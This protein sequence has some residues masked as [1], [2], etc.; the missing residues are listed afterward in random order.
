MSWD[1]D[2]FAFF[3]DLEGQAEAAYEA[4]RSAE[5]A[6][7]S[8]AEY[9]QVVLAGRLTASLGSPLGLDVQGVGHLEG[10]L[11]RVGTGWCL[12]QGRGQDWVV[13]LAAVTAVSGASPRSVPEVARSPIARL[14]LGSAL[15]RLADGRER[16]IMHLIDG[17]GHE[18]TVLR[19]GGDFVEIGVGQAGRVL[20]V[21][22]G[23]LAAVQSRD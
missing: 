13:R 4:E 15:R 6:D 16:C 17:A 11:D 9:Q 12:V 22:F 20:L 21:A 2:L 8:R 7:R 10:T 19:V 1:E 23:A 18:S 5:L 14:T 3:D